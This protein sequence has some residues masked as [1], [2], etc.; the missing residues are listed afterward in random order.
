MS[1]LKLSLLYKTTDKPW[2]GVNT[3]FRN[4]KRYAC[5]DD[6][7]ELVNDYSKA[8]V[9]LSAGHYIGPG[10]ILEKRHLINISRGLWKRNLLGKRHRDTSL[11]RDDTTYSGSKNL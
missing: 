4:F 3:F 6:R 11:P 9:L 5:L 7:I 2:G 8:D 10:S 1:K